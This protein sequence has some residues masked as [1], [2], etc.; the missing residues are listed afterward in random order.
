MDDERMMCPDCGHAMLW[1]HI[2]SYPMPCMWKCW[3]CMKEMRYD[4]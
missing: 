4:G 1:T 3:S 2:G